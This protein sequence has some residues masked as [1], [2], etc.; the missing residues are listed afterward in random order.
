MR[1]RDEAI[2]RRGAALLELV[3]GRFPMEFDVVGDADAWPLIGTSLVSRMT[4]T[5]RTVLAI[6]RLERW[7]DAGTLVRS[8]YEHS[9]HLAWLAADPSSA[10]IEQ[11]RRNDLRARLTADTECRERGAPLFSAAARRRLENQ[12]AD[13]RGERLKLVDVAAAADSYWCGRLPGLGGETEIQSFRGLYAVVYRMYSGVAHPT[14]RGIN[15][16]VQDVTAIRRRVV[17]EEPYIDNGPY[18]LAVVIYGLS[19]FVAATS[20]EWP[21]GATIDGV[22]ERFVVPAAMPYPATT[23]E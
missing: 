16:V 21:D 1:S 13:M 10:R 14:Y 19:L 6:Q 20:L 5:L 15:P 3:E 17:L 8:L 11:W 12:V 22:F 2:R 23:K 4:T 18:G 9:V 7:T